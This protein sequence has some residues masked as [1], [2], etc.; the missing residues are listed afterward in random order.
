MI[1][2]LIGKF[3]ATLH[4]SINTFDDDGDDDDGV[5]NNNNN[6]KN[7]RCIST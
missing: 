3:V 2:D 1:N 4:I 7:G 6:Q 5:D